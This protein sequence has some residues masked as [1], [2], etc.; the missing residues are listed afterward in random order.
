MGDVHP[1]FGAFDLDGCQVVRFN[2]GLDPH[3]LS[4]SG[5]SDGSLQRPYVEAFMAD[6]KR[7]PIDDRDAEVASGI[8]ARAGTQKT[9]KKRKLSNRRVNIILATLRLAL[10]RAVK[11]AGS[12]RTRP[13]RSR[14]SERRNRRSSPSPSR[15]S[16][17]SSTAGSGTRRGAATSPSP[18]SPGFALAS[19]WGSGGMTSTGRAS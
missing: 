13:G 14:R 1:G 6:L 2:A 17:S 19:S 9:T 18:S 5:V 4:S 12:R 16:G 15:R 8:P 10:D 11:R 3:A 7:A